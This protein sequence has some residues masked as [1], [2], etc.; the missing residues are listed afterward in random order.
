MI[1]LI[2]LEKEHQVEFKTEKN[3]LHEETTVLSLLANSNKNKYGHIIAELHDD[4]LKKNNHYPADMSAMYKLFDEHSNDK[5]A[6]N[7]NAAGAPH[8][9]FAQTTTGKF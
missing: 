2:N 7:V 6:I 3:K 9:V 8:L 1:I 5:K 4:Y